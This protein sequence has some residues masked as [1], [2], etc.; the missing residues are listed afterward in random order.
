[1]RTRRRNY[2]YRPN[3][4][5]HQKKGKGFFETL[6]EVIQDPWSV[7][8]SVFEKMK[9]AEEE[10]SSAKQK[11]PEEA[12]SLRDAFGILCPPLLLQSLNIKLYRAHARELLERIVKDHDLELLTHAELC[13]HLSRFSLEVPPSSDV[14]CLYNECFAAVFPKEYSAIFNGN[15]PHES[16]RGAALAI[17]IKLARSLRT[18]RGTETT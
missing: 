6:R 10:I 2:R 5:A 9:I 3:G 7:I 13:V 1:M 8:S 15:T 12:E 16:Y 18:K 14:A 17:K 11:H 4:T